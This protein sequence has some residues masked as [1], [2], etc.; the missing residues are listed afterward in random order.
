MKA[1]M[2]AEQLN[3]IFLILG[4]NGDGREMRL[5]KDRHTA[6]QLFSYLADVTDCVTI[7]QEY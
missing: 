5:L 6:C 1:E 3:T 4:G 2:K 7:L